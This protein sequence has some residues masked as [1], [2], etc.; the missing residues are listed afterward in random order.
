MLTYGPRQPIPTPRVVLVVYAG[1]PAGLRQLV[2]RRRQP[3]EVAD[4]AEAAVTGLADHPVVERLRLDARLLDAAVHDP[5]HDR[6]RHRGD[7]DPDHRDHHDELEQ[8]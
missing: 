1:K 2:E 4:E 8:V 7:E 3:A 6:R 5:L